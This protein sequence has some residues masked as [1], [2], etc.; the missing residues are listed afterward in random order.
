MLE[1]VDHEHGVVGARRE[2]GVLEDAL[3]HVESKVPGSSHA[4][5]RQLDTLRAPAAAAGLVEQQPDPAADVKDQW[6]TVAAEMAASCGQEL[7]GGRAAGALLGDIGFVDHP[8]VGGLELVLDHPGLEH[9]TAP[10]AV[11]LRLLAWVVAGRGDLFAGGGGGGALVG[12][13]ELGAPADPAGRG[14]QSGPPLVRPGEGRGLA[15][16]P[17]VN[18]FSAPSAT[19]AGQRALRPGHRCATFAA[20][21]RGGAVW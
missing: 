1:H 17:R 9:A 10:A 8:G 20:A 3:E 15:A 19:R 4:P 7:P 21:P 14:G 13:R 2:V 16:K 5:V 6:W 11:Q 12:Q 18:Q